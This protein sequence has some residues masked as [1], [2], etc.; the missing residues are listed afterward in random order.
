[1]SYEAKVQP[2]DRTKSLEEIAIENRSKLG[3][4]FFNMMK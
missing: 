1:M 2:T 4:H 3:I